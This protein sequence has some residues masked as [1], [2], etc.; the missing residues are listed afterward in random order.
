[1]K[2]TT[3]K[4]YPFRSFYKG[5]ERIAFYVV[6]V[7]GEEP[8]ISVYSD[9]IKGCDAVGFSRNQLEKNRFRVH[10]LLRKYL[11]EELADTIIKYAMKDLGI[12]TKFSLES[13]IKWKQTH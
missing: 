12:K 7:L 5:K 1:M 8:S 9:Y 2:I 10:D 13:Y 4:A 11:A 3:R 6:E